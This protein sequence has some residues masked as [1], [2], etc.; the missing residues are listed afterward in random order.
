MNRIW[1]VLALFTLFTI[2]LFGQGI[3]QRVRGTVVDADSKI[4][5]IGRN[6]QRGKII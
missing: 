5:L 1:L 4:S 2:N 6:W 3:T